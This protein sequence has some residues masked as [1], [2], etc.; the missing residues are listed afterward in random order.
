LIFLKGGLSMSVAD[1][2]LIGLFGISVVFVVLVG[3]SLLVRL[4]SAL[5]T[6]FTEKKQAVNTAHEAAAAPDIKAAPVLKEDPEP[7]ESISIS[8]PL[9]GTVIEILTSPGAHVHQGQTLLILD[10]MKMEQEITSPRDGTV[11]Q[12]LKSKGASVGAGVPLITLQ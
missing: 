12:V 10:T 1:S 11:L 7:L 4:E 8:A 9:Y 5:I 2:L 6:R 3:L